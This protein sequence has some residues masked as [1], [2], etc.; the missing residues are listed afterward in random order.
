MQKQVV[1]VGGVKIPKLWSQG[2]APR[3]D[4][5]PEARV[6]TRSSAQDEG[7]ADGGGGDGHT[8]VLQGL[9]D[10]F[11]KTQVHSLFYSELHS[12]ARSRSF[13]PS[14]CRS[15]ARAPSEALSPSSPP[16][17]PTILRAFCHSCEH[18]RVPTGDNGHDTYNTNATKRHTGR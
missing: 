1:Q 14:P 11:G 10:F 8:V 12:L 17:S 5:S 13:S 9:A 18:L 16:T 2:N 6:S 3:A 7:G 4:L 15:L